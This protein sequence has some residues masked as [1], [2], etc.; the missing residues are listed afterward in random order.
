MDPSTP[1]QQP[2]ASSDR[3]YLLLLALGLVACFAVA[4]VGVA[5]LVVART[6]PM[7]LAPTAV[8]TPTLPNLPDTEGENITMAW[9]SMSAGQWGHAIPYLDRAIQLAPQDGNAYYYRATCYYNLAAQDHI[10]TDFLAHTAQGRQ[11]IDNAIAYGI[12]DPNVKRGDPYY[13]RY[14]IY[15]QTQVESNAARVAFQPVLREN[16]RTAE[17]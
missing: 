2:S 12:I 9:Q 13:L 1:K 5:V 6:V 15:A 7:L 14:E 16:L 10:Q 8:D 3:T 11:D 17:A 4:G